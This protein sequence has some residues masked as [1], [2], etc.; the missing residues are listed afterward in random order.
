MRFEGA[1]GGLLFYT[2]AETRSAIEEGFE[3]PEEVLQERIDASFEEYIQSDLHERFVLER[4]NAVLEK[5]N[6]EIEFDSNIMSASANTRPDVRF[7]FDSLRSENSE[8]EKLLTNEKDV[9]RHVNRLMQFLF[10]YITAL[11]VDRQT[12]LSL[13]MELAGILNKEEGKND[14]VGLFAEG[15][16]KGI[17]GIVGLGTGIFS[18]ISKSIT[19]GLLGTDWKR[20]LIIGA[21]ILIV[22]I[23]VILIGFQFTKTF[24]SEKAK[25]KAN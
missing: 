22:V 24:V 10:D 13:I 15:V 16:G 23:V 12:E 19:E 5:Y 20:K 17:S 2:D 1:Q 6:H 14:I 4:I 8:L 21:I 7:K 11:K 18:D 3:L 25:Q 9:V